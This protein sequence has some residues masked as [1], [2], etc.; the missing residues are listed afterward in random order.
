MAGHAER[1]IVPYDAEQMYDLVADVGS[2]KEF[3]PWC[4]ASRV[5]R[6]EQREGGA[7]TVIDADLVISFRVFR[8]K[9]SSR[10]TLRP[11]D[12]TIDVAYLDGP[13]RY[14]DNH[15]HFTQLAPGQ[16]EIDFAVDFEFRNLALDR[17]VGAVFHRAMERIVG[18]FEAR[19]A[20]LYG[21]AGSPS[22]V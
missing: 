8:E 7:I 15:W 16:C 20:D 9:F 21:G 10:V 12:L 22:G 11:A 6:R 1:R 19:A 2:Y 4:A 14:L 18:A 13:F 3:L 17:L 5:T